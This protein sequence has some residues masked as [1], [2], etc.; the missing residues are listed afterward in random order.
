MSMYTVHT[1]SVMQVR[2]SQVPAQQDL[3]AD[4]QPQKRKNFADERAGQGA[5]TQH[6][7]ARSKREVGRA[8][9]KSSRLGERLRS[10]DVARKPYLPH[11]NHAYYC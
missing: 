4:A 11:H 8:P 6:A 7:Q 3:P 5:C 1:I 2:D 9:S 10:S